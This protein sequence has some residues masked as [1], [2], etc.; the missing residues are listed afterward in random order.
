MIRWV[1]WVEAKNWP[2]FPTG[3]PEQSAAPGCRWMRSWSFIGI[4]DLF[5]SWFPFNFLLRFTLAIYSH[6]SKTSYPTH[7]TALRH[8]HNTTCFTSASSITPKCLRTRVSRLVSDSSSPW[9]SQLPISFAS[10]S[11]RPKCEIYWAS[12][13]Y[14]GHASRTS[15][16]VPVCVA[17]ATK[18]D[19]KIQSRHF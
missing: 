19:A 17:A 7:E 6:N 4:T 13:L 14:H 11:L 12:C 10:C 3:R 1:A 9:P 5:L 15:H 2:L 16:R 8:I 18:E